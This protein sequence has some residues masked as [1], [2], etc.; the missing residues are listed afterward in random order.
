MEFIERHAPVEFDWEGFDTFGVVVVVT[1]VMNV[2]E[3]IGDN[4]GVSGCGRSKGRENGGG[5]GDRG[6]EGGGG[7]KQ[8][9]SKQKISIILKYCLLFQT[10]APPA[11]NILF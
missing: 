11:K 9:C 1:N 2:G 6:G 5:V 8:T 3:D 4:G 7:G 10:P